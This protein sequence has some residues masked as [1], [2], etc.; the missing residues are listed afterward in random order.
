MRAP[1][2]SVSFPRA[3]IA[4]YEFAKGGRTPIKMTWYDGGLLPGRPPVMPADAEINPTGGAMLIGDKGVAV[5][6]TY[7]HNPR[8]F[9][10]H[11]EEEYANVPQSL[12]RI[13]TSH[14][15][16]WANACMGIGEASSPISYAAPLTETMLLGM[17]ALR[18]G[19][20]KKLYWD[21]D[22]G[23]FTNDDNANQYLH[24]EYRSGWEL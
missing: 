8:L 20:G 23:Q 17:A 18:N 19:Y 22:K 5:Y 3:S 11:L 6:D 4:H 14:E 24:Y 12:H 10:Q 15:M 16:C 13:Q 21:A 9:P 7:G 2:G 1:V